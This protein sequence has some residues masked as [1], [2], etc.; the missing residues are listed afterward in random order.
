MVGSNSSKKKCTPIFLSKCPNVQYPEIARFAGRKYQLY[1][2]YMNRINWI[3]SHWWISTKIK[4]LI[5][6]CSEFS[7][8][9]LFFKFFM[10]YWENLVIIIE[11]L[12][13][14]IFILIYVEWTEVLKYRICI[15]FIDH[16]HSMLF[17]YH[18][19]V[20]KF[21]QHYYKNVFYLV[22]H[23]ISQNYEED[24]L[25]SF[26]IIMQECFDYSTRQNILITFK[27]FARE[28]SIPVDV[29]SIVGKIQIRLRVQF[30]FRI[31]ARQRLYK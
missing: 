19:N 30:L 28:F 25:S 21:F 27:T 5:F 17:Q 4:W 23:I 13:I 6:I 7:H 11:F 14:L 9:F 2:I 24:R 16:H 1:I 8:W 20:I 10:I 22:E 3:V 12:K 26:K 31:F 18:L 15:C 29:T